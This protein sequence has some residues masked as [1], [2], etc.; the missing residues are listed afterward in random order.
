MLI[1]NHI[2]VSVSNDEL[3]LSCDGN[4]D[5]P[6]D[7]IARVRSHKKEL[8]GLLSGHKAGEGYVPIENTASASD[9]VVSERQ[10]G[11]WTLCQSPEGSRAY[12]IY[13]RYEL[14]GR[15][16]HIENFE[17]AVQKAIDRHEILRTVFRLNEQDELRQVVLP[18]DRVHFRCK[19]ADLQDPDEADVNR[20]LE[21]EN[22][23]LYD[24][25]N[26]PL[27][28]AG[29]IKAKG[30]DIL[31]VNMH[32]I[33]S[34]GLSIRMLMSE[35]IGY[36]QVFSLGIE[37]HVAPL[38][39]QYKDFS[40][41]EAGQL[42][43]GNFD[44]HRSYW[45]N[46]LSGE[47]PLVQLPSYK[48]RPAVRTHTG[49]KL[50]SAIGSETYRDLK[51]YVQLAGGTVFMGLVAIFKCLAYRYAGLEDII[52]GTPVAGR[53]HPDL[54]DQI[55]FY[56]N[57]LPLRTR[58]KGSDRFADLFENVKRSVLGAFQ[59]QQYPFDRLVDDLS[60][61]RDVSRSPIF[62][63]S[64]VL[65]NEDAGDERPGP[66][67]RDVVRDRGSCKAKFDLLIAF[68]EM[69]ECLEMEVELNTEVY[70]TDLI[71]GFIRHY[72]ALMAAV[73]ADPCKS[74][75]E[76][77]FLPLC[78][79][80]KLEEG[81]GGAVEDYGFGGTV[82]DLFRERVSEGPL[83]VALRCG[84]EEMSYG[85]LEERSDRLSR[86]LRRKGVERGQLVPVC[87]DRG[88]ELVVCLLGVVK[89][90]AAYVPIDPR[91]SVGRIGYMLGEVNAGFIISQTEYKELFEEQRG[92]VRF[93]VDRDWVAVEMEAEGELEGGA[94]AGGLA[95]VM[96]TSGSTGEPKGVMIGHDQLYNYLSYCRARYMPVGGVAY[97]TALFTSLSFDLTVT[98]LFG[99][100]VSGGSVEIYDSRLSVAEVMRDI[101]Y[102]GRGIN[103]VKCTPS[104]LELLGGMEKGR[105]G[106][107]IVVVG[108]EELKER[109]LTTLFELNEGMVVYN[110]YGP[111]EA[112]V[113]CIVEAIRRGE[114][115]GVICIGRPVSNMRAYLLDEWGGPVPMGL[116]GELY[117]EGIQV[118]RGYWGKEEQTREVFVEE[119]GRRRYRTGDKGRW[120]ADGRMVYMGRVDEQVKIRGYRVEPAEVEKA[121]LG[122][123][124]AETAV[125]TAMSNE[126]GGQELV[127][128]MVGGEERGGRKCDGGWGKCCR[129]IWCRHTAS[130][131]KVCR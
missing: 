117:V 96:Y 21:E 83:A 58:L 115:S 127:A 29:I 18:E 52:V 72:K 116:E 26:G 131:W 85:E 67:D 129:S 32:H 62:D 47:L 118:A 98:G 97:R 108:G 34:D 19:I 113:G 24:L 1:D 80:S 105:S 77:S 124:M 66:V 13:H 99:T 5:I 51:N 64:L 7:I 75:R 82:V 73:V 17:K 16:L 125:V 11:L 59:H 91:Y 53:D 42:S 48:T 10:K 45:L 89:C 106:V 20:Y 68:R 25:A 6:D 102:G 94:E 2:T 14:G 50:A 35:V 60:L 28:F 88:M 41:W 109:H 81:S 70:D 110:E 119:G 130:G 122:L 33:I 78:E 112:T 126:E 39:I 57:M 63:I 103:V 123:G 92:A 87:M 104:H 55:G 40:A 128:Y 111:T 31:Y 101:F 100:L 86:Y 49:R 37:P 121:L 9:Y 74:L 71:S 61:R 54:E 84:G 12:N 43:N 120:L 90:G 8:I 4:T 30:R 38:R 36:L 46:Q 3:R 69:T 56:S 114:E 22:L 27:L 107:E 44:L 76:Y 95:Y 65:H 93:Y 15:E 23:R 79:L